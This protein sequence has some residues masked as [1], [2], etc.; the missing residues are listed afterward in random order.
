[1]SEEREVVQAAARLERAVEEA[2][3]RYAGASESERTAGIATALR[4]AL[5]AEPEA[6]H[7]AALEQMVEWYPLIPVRTDDPALAAELGE[8]R[9]EV[10]RLRQERSATPAAAPAA[11]SSVDRALLEALLGRGAEKEATPPPERIV[12][13][14]R[15]LTAL[16][17]DLARAF[18]A[19]TAK[20]GETGLHADR[21]RTAL[22]GELAGTQPAGSLQALL[23]EIKLKVA[24]QL[25]AFPTA[26]AD[27]A[28]QILKELDPL[29][30]KDQAD[31][32]KEGVRLP[33]GFRPFQH[34]EWWETFEKRHAELTASDDLYQTY[35][36]GPLRRALY[37]LKERK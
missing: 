8:L 16:A 32:K 5:A 20:A 13:S 19:I 3:S 26:C 23:D 6:V 15:A 30:L 1:V 14:V 4:Q 34:R 36:D 31:E 27:G 37:R 28:R 12:A 7:S 33:G 22:R 10:Q 2:H 35:F 24:G 9:A 29:L 11:P 25:E 17:A 21:F 18:L